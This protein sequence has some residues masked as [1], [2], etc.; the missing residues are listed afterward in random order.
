MIKEKQ[1]S[2]TTESLKYHPKML[3]F[4][5]SHLGVILFKEIT[6]NLKFHHVL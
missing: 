5:K 1:P 6:I 4:L 3:G 2:G